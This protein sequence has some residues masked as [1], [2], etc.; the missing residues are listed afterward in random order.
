[1]LAERN[2][3]RVPDKKYSVM[4]VKLLQLEAR[5]KQQLDKIRQQSMLTSPANEALKLQTMRTTRQQSEKRINRRSVMDSP[6]AGL[7][8]NPDFSYLA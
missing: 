1:M 8:I 5:Q 3:P 2:N 7:K 4:G 6:R